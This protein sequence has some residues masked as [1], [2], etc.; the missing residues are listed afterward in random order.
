MGII[1]VK[2]IS[3]DAI[4]AEQRQA[5][6]AKAFGIA[7][8]KRMG[9]QAP[10]GFVFDTTYFTS[11]AKSS[12]AYERIELLQSVLPSIRLE[13]I[14]KLSADIVECLRSVDLN[15]EF[16]AELQACFD[17]LAGENNTV[18]CRS[19]SSLEDGESSAF[20]GV[21]LSVLDIRDAEQLKRAV[22]DCYCSLMS[23]RAIKYLVNRRLTAATPAMSLIVQRQVHP[24]VSGVAFSCDPLIPNDKTVHVETVIG[25]GDGL[26]S[27][28]EKPFKYR[29]S[30][31]GEISGENDAIASGPLRMDRVTALADAVV[32]LRTRF[33]FDV[34]VEFAFQPDETTP[35]ILQCR[36]V[37]AFG[38]AGAACQVAADANVTDALL[39]VTCAPGAVSGVGID[40][41][42]D[43]LTA[44]DLD[45][46]IVLLSSLTTDNYESLFIA[47][48]VVSEGPD[49]TLSHM[50]I[51]CRELGIPYMAAVENACDRLAGETIHIDGGRGAVYV[52]NAELERPVA[53]ETS[54]T[55][56]VE[57]KR[58]RVG[59]IGVLKDL[60]IPQGGVIEFVGMA[61]L[62]IESAWRCSSIRELEA[63]VERS[64]RQALLE[65]PD[66]RF[67]V[68]QPR[69]QSDEMRAFRDTVT[70][71]GDD[72]RTLHEMIASTVMRLSRDFCQVE[73]AQQPDEFGRG[74]S[75]A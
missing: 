67:I 33:G 4:S 44:D 46:G 43:C 68:F 13:H 74:E 25:L 32:R 49:S 7:E 57:P 23:S 1:A 55:P 62:I 17:D 56:I 31:G 2:M 54:P 9:L 45:S 6:G 34:D 19:S 48:G 16:Q 26:V 75:D 30:T 21:F 51:A 29:I 15:S 36:P 71:L 47:R 53:E 66:V 59:Y 39:G 18:V 42:G 40:C 14:G 5:V 64:L 38:G 63:D 3:I 11:F 20:P 58:R 41:R 52:I 70:G 61:S 69:F 12:G 65:L 8:A 27:G 73:L 24:E 60:T 37:T 72:Q 28:R 22:I 35:T 10:E 50:S